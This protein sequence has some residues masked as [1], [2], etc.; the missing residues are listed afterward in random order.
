MS[1]R[2]AV[3]TAAAVVTPVLLGFW[4]VDW[5]YKLRA[6]RKLAAYVA[7]LSQSAYMDVAG[8]RLEAPL[9]ALDDYRRKGHAFTLNPGRDA[10]DAEV[11]RSDFRAASSNS[12]EPLAVP[13]VTITIDTWG[14]D[15]FG[16]RDLFQTICPNLRQQWARS[17][18]DNPWSALQQSLPI[19]FDLADRNQIDL[20][21][22]SSFAGGANTMADH[23]RSMRLV[24]DQTEIACDA[25]RAVTGQDLCTASRLI[26]GDLIAVWVADY[27]TTHKDL[28][29]TGEAISALVAFG[30]GPEEHFADLISL[31]CD[32][33][34][35][36][37]A[38]P[39][40]D[41]DK[42]C[43]GD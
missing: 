27:D 7:T 6:E 19:R 38:K 17:I 36:N 2:R 34:P 40:R 13:R 14:W 22:S 4:L 8:V 31:A 15:D 28:Q 35:A 24:P 12:D 21:D 43:P 23:L 1:F 42:E 9:A 26:R 33:R 39:F 5:I 25:D 37:H 16:H 32:A 41:A 30:L 3:I 20:F 29:K 11:R 10:E 18:C